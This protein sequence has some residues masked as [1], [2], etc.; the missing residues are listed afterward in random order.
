[1]LA[2]VC[3]IVA[4]LLL[5]KIARV[6]VNQL[7][8]KAHSDNLTK[9]EA[10]GFAAQLL[11]WFIGLEIALHLLGIHLSALFAAGGA[12]AI[13]VGLAA[14]NVTEDFLSSWMLKSGRIIRPGDIVVADGKWLHIQHVGL[15]HITAKTGDGEDILI[16][17][18]SITKSNV[19]NLT[20]DDRLHRIQVEVG[21]ACDSDLDQVRKLLEQV[22]VETEWRSKD[23][24]ATVY[25]QDL[26]HLRIVYSISLWV[27]D[28]VQS[29]ARQS[30]LREAVWRA[31]TGADIT[32]A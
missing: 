6:T 19:Q 30:D 16:P 9:T 22:I 4:T 17:N 13:S 11:V 31:L 24:E 25:L 32:I 2:V 7:A 20:R 18:S 10:Y 27:D 28:V 8:R 23:K 14:K 3:V 5:A 21:V 1:M 29:G 26:G 15:R 12:L